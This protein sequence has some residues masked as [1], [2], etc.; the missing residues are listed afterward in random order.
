[1]NNFIIK[2]NFVYVRSRCRYEVV[3]K[4]D[5]FYFE[6][7]GKSVLMHCR[8]KDYPISISISELEKILSGT[9]NWRIHR[10]FI[11]NFKQV[12]AADRFFVHLTNGENVPIGRKFLNS[13]KQKFLEAEF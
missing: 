3:N 12:T 8:E 10:S 9:Y 7:S 2:E 4:Q 6:A 1:M 5:V 13:V 11:V